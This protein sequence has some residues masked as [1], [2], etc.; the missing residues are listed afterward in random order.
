MAGGHGPLTGDAPARGVSRSGALSVWGSPGRR[1]LPDLRYSLSG[2]PPVRVLLVAC[3]RTGSSTQARRLELPE[4]LNRA[5][6]WAQ[7]ENPALR[8][9][10]TDGVDASPLALLP[11]G[12]ARVLGNPGRSPGDLQGREGALPGRSHAPRW[13]RRTAEDAGREDAW[14]QQ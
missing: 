3:P 6:Q 7:L 12:A 13:P 2:A 5:V 9:L 10:P 8:P 11:S 14:P 4:L 1:M